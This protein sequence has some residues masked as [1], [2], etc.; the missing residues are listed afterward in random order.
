[1][2]QSSV[3]EGQVNGGVVFWY[4]AGSAGLRSLSKIM[5]FPSLN[6]HLHVGENL[7]MDNK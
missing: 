3:G 1:M 5:K 6:N 2:R 4:I 7:K